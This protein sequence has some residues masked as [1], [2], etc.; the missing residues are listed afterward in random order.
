MSPHCTYLVQSRDDSHDLARSQSYHDVTSYGIHR[1]NTFH[2]T[3]TN[4]QPVH[5]STV[6]KILCSE[7]TQTLRTGCSKAEP[8]IFAP[9]Q[10][11]FPWVWDG[12]NLISW[13]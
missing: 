8:K 6:M 1:V 4:K 9:L 10:T 5:E 13:R 2:F 11:P 12:Q 7:E 3:A